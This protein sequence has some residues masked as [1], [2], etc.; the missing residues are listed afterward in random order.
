MST[1]SLVHWREWNDA[2]FAEAKADDKPVLLHIG[3]VWCHWCHVMDRGVPGDPTHTGVYTNP[4]L[5]DYVNEHFIPV[6]V[7][8]DQRPDI[9][10]RYNQ[11]G[12]PTTCFL[13]PDGDVIYGGTYFAPGQMRQLLPQISKHWSTRKPD[14]LDQ[15]AERGEPDLI[16]TAVKAPQQTDPL[17]VQQIVDRVA[18][19]ITRGYDH[20]NFGLGD[21]QKF[22]MSDAW[23]LLLA[24]QQPDNDHLDMVVNTL[25]AMGT[26]GMYDLTAGGW[27][28]YSTTPDW[29]VPHFEKMLEDHARLLPVY[30]HAIQSCRKGRPAQ[31]AELEKIVRSSLKYLEATLLHD[32]D[33][34][35]YFAGSQD[36]D[37]NYYA[38]SM[39]ERAT[40]TAPFIDWRMYADWNAL[41][42]PALILAAHVLQE[43]RYATCARKVLDTI[44]RLCLNPD[45]SIT[46]AVNFQAGKPVPASL[47]GMLGDQASVALALLSC[48][49]HA[50][51]ERVLAFA[52]NTLAAPD[53]GYYDHP[54]DP[55]AHGMLRV[56]LK[57]I[58]DNA[59]M[60]EALL[61]AHYLGD[62]GLATH[63]NNAKTALAAFTDEYVRYREHGAAYALACMHATTEPTE[64]I[65]VGQGV[66]VAALE[67]AGY[68]GYDAWRF[69]RV[70]DPVR[71]ATWIATRGY[72]VTRL[73]AAFICHG[74]TCSAPIYDPALLYVAEMK[75]RVAI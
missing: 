37:E 19:A 4:Q 3:A 63:V 22:P 49:E 66:G 75:A 45:G 9:N 5:A 64:L 1:T 69:V 10:A 7:D 40:L 72:P 70:V 35:T 46:H 71:D 74:T 67:A 28:R 27:F 30:L 65:V 18:A 14:L 29:T 54:V 17:P 48:G 31:A 2:S 38:L 32:A 58:F 56:R 59:H 43:P 41:M 34:I 52:Q 26:R 61:H 39:T 62:A 50:V 25:I 33:D 73:P 20:R 47:L 55:A 57:P 12:W 16:Q 53:G 23:A 36:A 21:G 13:T 68:G 60:A 42:V 24:T 15:I 44:T 6:R 8:N 51:A 11:G